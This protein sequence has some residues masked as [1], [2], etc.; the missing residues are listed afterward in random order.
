PIVVFDMR[1]PGVPFYAHKHVLQPPSEAAL[2]SV[3]TD[4]PHACVITKYKRQALFDSLPGSRT[5]TREGQF[6]LVEWRAP[7]KRRT[8]ANGL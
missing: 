5:A 7:S 4:L 6:M 2:K 3:L 1:K 8:G